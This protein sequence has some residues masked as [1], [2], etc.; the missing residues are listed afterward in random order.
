MLDSGFVVKQWRSQNSEKVTHVKGR[1]RD[2]AT[3]LFNCVPFFKGNF[4]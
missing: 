2:Q 3:V 4:S 1:L